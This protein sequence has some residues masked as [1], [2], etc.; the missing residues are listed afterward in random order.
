MSECPGGDLYQRDRGAGS[1]RVGDVNIGRPGFGLS[2]SGMAIRLRRTIVILVFGLWAGVGV[3]DGG[4]GVTI[5]ARKPVA[6]DLLSLIEPAR[7][8]IKG[9]VVATAG[10]LL[11]DSPWYFVATRLPYLPSDQYD[12][13]FEVT[14]TT[15]HD[16]IGIVL[17]VSA[18][19]QIAL[20]LGGYPSKGGLD[21]LNY[22]DGKDLTENGTGTKT[23]IRNG[24]SLTIKVAVRADQVSYCCQCG[25]AE[26]GAV[27]KIA[28]R[29][30]NID[31]RA[32][33]LRQRG[34][35]IYQ[36][37]GESRFTKIV[38]HDYGHGRFLTAWA[39]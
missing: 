12:L 16:G 23:C 35:A 9:T 19:R 18:Q 1:Q 13:E 20:V 17:P 24:E 29:D 3:G 6:I 21:G 22:V 37:K 10:V 38:L 11:L 28:G 31:E 33:G 15:G 2:N 26:V 30:L 8:R 5:G 25:A 36:V 27:F 7:D 39:K 4:K 14:R 32:G 34:L